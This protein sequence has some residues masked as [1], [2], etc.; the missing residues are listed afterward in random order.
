MY[1]RLG[2][3]VAPAPPRSVARRPLSSIVKNDAPR[4]SLANDWAS[5]L[6]L[7]NL[8]KIAPNAVTRSESTNP[9]NGLLSRAARCTSWITSTRSC[10]TK[11]G[12]GARD[13][14]EV[15]GGVVLPG[16]RQRQA[17]SLIHI[18]EPTS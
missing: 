1:H 9:T 14:R 15:V 16:D 13:R 2:A 4:T 12:S 11:P 18:S 10:E 6:A 8:A 7:G 17:L 3:C 5:D